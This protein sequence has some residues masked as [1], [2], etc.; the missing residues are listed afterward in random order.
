MGNYTQVDDMKLKSPI[1]ELQG[2]DGFD[3]IEKYVNFDDGAFSWGQP[4]G[5]HGETNGVKW[6]SYTLRMSSQAWMADETLKSAWTHR[7]T[8]FVPE[9]YQ[10]GMKNSDVAAL[11]IDQTVDTW[12]AQN[13]AVET[14]V[15]TASVSDVPNQDLTFPVTGHNLAEEDLKAWSWH[16]FANDAEHPEWPIEMPDVKAVVRAMDAIAAYTHQGTLPKVNRFIV[17]GHSKR[18]MAAWMVGAV[19]KRVEA[20]VPLGMPLNLLQVGQEAAKD[21]GGIVPYSRPYLE[22]G[23]LNLTKE[24]VTKLAAINDPVHY[25]KRL[26]IPKLLILS[27]AD[28]FFPPDCTRSW[29]GDLPKP[30]HIYV[31]GK[32]RHYGYDIKWNN[33]NK[34]LEVAGAF[35]SRIV[36]GDA[37]PEI[38]WKID[39]QDGTIMVKQVSNHTPSAV[40]VFG[41]KTKDQGETRDF[42]NSDWMFYRF[43][44]PT[45]QNDRI[46]LVKS[47]E[48]V[49]W[50]GFFVAFEY[51]PVRPGGLPVRLTTE[52][53]VTPSTRPFPDADG[54]LPEWQDVIDPPEDSFGL[55]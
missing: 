22:Y 19:D 46:W 16:K 21:I 47:P 1:P 30:K 28:D 44:K 40:R 42:R 35:V 50:V 26:T 49:K 24:Q 5:D 27:G 54:T 53:S 31:Y 48:R 8:I 15:V 39:N 7:I 52:V 18:A 23:D 41:A 33:G 45:E 51:E 17:T 20:I 12:A 9:T 10:G 36:Y 14:G 32:G 25:I 37:M 43:V 2:C 29:W 6:A 11:F 3:C 55:R 13:M 34:F 4:A 38:A